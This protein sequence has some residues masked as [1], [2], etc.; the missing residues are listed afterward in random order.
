MS[1]T[2]AVIVL[3]YLTP[4]SVISWRS[5]LLVEKT[6]VPG[7]NTDLPQVTDKLDH[8]LFYRTGFELTTLVM[9][10]TVCIGSCESQYQTFTTTLITN[11]NDCL[12]KLK[13]TKV[14][15]NKNKN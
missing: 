3:L 4:L 12:S 2:N 15:I 13:R 5:V 10:Y 11:G 1:V 7:K 14:I 9:I 8:I 6:E